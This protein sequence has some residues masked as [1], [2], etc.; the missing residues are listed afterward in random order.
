VFSHA[1]RVNY[2]VPEGKWTNLLSGKVM[3]GP[4][5]VRETHDFMSL[6]LLVRPNSV[7]PMGSRTDKPDYDYSDGVTLQVYQLEDGKQ[8]SVEIPTLDGKIETRFEVKREENTIHIEREGSA[9]AWNVSLVGIDAV[10][11]VENAEMEI[12]NGSTLIKV[13]GEI[14]ELNV[15]LR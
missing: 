8:V 12:V 2:Y 7:I 9:K 3:E 4:R 6:P 13:N 1:G 15:R 5:W 14:N 11:N 10:E